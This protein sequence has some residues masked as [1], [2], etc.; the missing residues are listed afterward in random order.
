MNRGQRRA[1]WR[2]QHRA[3]VQSHRVASRPATNAANASIVASHV[4]ATPGPASSVRLHID[5]LV[6]H[7]FSAG[8]R[9]SIGEATQQELSRLLTVRGVPAG[10]TMPGETAQIDGGNFHIARTAKPDAIGALVA[11]AVYGGWKR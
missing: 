3:R 2:S 1:Q 11:E 10:M 4:S 9:Y 7:G 6:L 5:E 8:S